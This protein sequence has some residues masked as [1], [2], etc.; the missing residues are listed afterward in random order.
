LHTISKNSQSIFYFQS[1]TVSF[2]QKYFDRL[3]ISLF[4]SLK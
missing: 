4:N 2:F 1:T 3:K